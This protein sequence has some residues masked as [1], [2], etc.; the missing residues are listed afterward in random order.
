MSVQALSR[1]LHIV[2]RWSAEKGGFFHFAIADVG[3]CIGA[4]NFGPVPARILEFSITG[5]RFEP[6]DSSDGWQLVETITDEASATSRIWAF[7]A[8]PQKSYDLLTNNCE[9]FVWYVAD[10]RRKS[11]Q[12]RHVAFAAATLAILFLGGSGNG[13]RA[14]APL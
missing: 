13:T 8:A 2:K 10:G 5:M 7:V 11:T 4:A 12:V 3:N 6:Y 9:H 1:G 14:V